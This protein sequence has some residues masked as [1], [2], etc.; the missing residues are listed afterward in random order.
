MMRKGS[1]T[2]IVLALS[3]AVLAIF[4]GAA[5][6]KLFQGNGAGGDTAQSGQF[7]T[8]GNNKE[9]TETQEN[10]GRRESSAKEAGETIE[11]SSAQS[12]NTEESI[13]AEESEQ[14]L[15]ERIQAK[16][17]DMSLEE[18]A[19]QLF[20]ITP[21]ALTG[22]SSVTQAGETSRKAFYQYP[23]GGVV[24][25][26]ENILSEPQVTLLLQKYQEYS[27]ERTGLPLFT[28][29]DEE[30]GQV[31][32][33][34]SCPGIDVPSFEDMAELGASMNPELA[35]EA[36]SAIGE[37]LNRMGFNLDFAPVADV[38]TNTNNTVVKRRS[39]GSDPQLVSEMV[40]NTLEGLKQRRVFGCVKH[41]PGHG[42]TV[43][44]THEGYA[45]TD[46]T[47]QEL[48]RSE[49][50][51]FE[52]SIAWGVS[53]IMVGHISL[54]DETEDQV[55]AS[56][57]SHI[58]QALLRGEMGY[59]GIVL[60]D[61]LNMKAI[62]DKYSSSEAAVKAILA[63]NDMLLMPQDFKSA[64]EGILNAVQEGIVTEERIDESLKRILTVKLQ[65]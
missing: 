33:I 15:Q 46:K 61:G 28:A 11:E 8:E 29:V 20:I 54:P 18:K 5:A 31:V 36:G 35:A 55:P 12:E 63:G 6:K 56:L 3:L 2:K 16:L 64:Y 60:T 62:A 4:L 53:F 37:Y 34:A 32:R 41:F 50:I 49:I 21:E 10:K 14:Q 45:Y 25:F 40:L 27:A 26:E 51:P 47:W 13:T 48:R 30:G 52:S 22:G 39:F 23:V 43:G 65:M 42:A 1:K 57:S 38:L 24:L 44:D 17:A 59:N 9:M 7:G 58:I 19:A